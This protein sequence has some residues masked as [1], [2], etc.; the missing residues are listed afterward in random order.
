MRILIIK[1]LFLFSVLYSFNATASDA[2]HKWYMNFVSKVPQKEER[3]IQT[4]VAYLSRPMQ[5]DYD[6]AQAFAYWIASHIIYDKF[7]YS[8]GEVTKLGKKYN[9]QSISSILQTR[10]GLCVDYATLFEE[11]CKQAGIKAGHIDGYAVDLNGNL[12]RTNIL[13]NNAHRWNYFIYNNRTV[14]V[15]PTWMASGQL[16]AKRMITEYNHKMAI[17]K[18]TLKNRNSCE[19]YNVKPYY[20][21]FTYKAEYRDMDVKRT[22]K[23]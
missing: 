11:M 3:S 6:K 23:N 19:I 7:L 8:A 18:N 13:K 2:R 1:F 16:V 21:D 15:D 10:V 12:S 5:N 4:L 14:Y 22:E 20:F 17:K 9:K